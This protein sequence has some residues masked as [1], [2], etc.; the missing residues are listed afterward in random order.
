MNNLRTNYS[1]KQGR[2]T[3]VCTTKLFTK[4]F[5]EMAQKIANIVAYD[6]KLRCT[7]YIL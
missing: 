7:K 1:L 5:D 4:V 2:G 6:C 3:L